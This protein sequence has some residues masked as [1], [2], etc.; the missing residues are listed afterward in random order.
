MS[1][2]RGS[3]SEEV[4]GFLGQA[5]EARLLVVDRQTETFHQLSH[6]RECY[7]SVAGSTG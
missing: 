1:T 2:F 7:R 5:R 3:H 4:K 6:D